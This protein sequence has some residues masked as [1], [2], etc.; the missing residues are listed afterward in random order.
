MKGSS[1]VDES[2]IAWSTGNGRLRGEIEASDTVL[3]TA[4]FAV[5]GT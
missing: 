4:S 3:M 5:E 2:V 1:A